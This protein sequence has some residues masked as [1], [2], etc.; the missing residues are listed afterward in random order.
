MWFG[1]LVTMDWF[2]DVWMKEVFANF[3]AAKIV[4]PSFPEVNHDLRFMLAHYPSAYAVDRSQGT[5]PIQQ[6]LEN[7]KNAGT[8]YGSII[9]QKAP[10][11]MRKLERRIGE[12]AMK[13]GLQQYLNAYS[14][15]NASWDDLITILDDQSEDDISSW[16]SKWVKEKGMA[17]ISAWMRTRKDSTVQKMN[18]FQRDM[19]ND[20]RTWPQQL[21]IM[22]IARDSTSQTNVDIEEYHVELADLEGTP[23]PDFIMPNAGGYG[24]GYFRLGPQTTHRLLTRM[25]EFDDPIVRGAG[26]MNLYERVLYGQTTPA[27]L[28]TSLQEQLVMEQEQLIVQRMLNYIETLYWKFLLPEDRISAADSVEQLLWQQL[29]QAEDS[30]VK[31]VYFNSFRSVILSEAG[32][33]R[34][35]KIWLKELKV[36][37]LSLSETD[38]T[39]MAYELALRLP[40][41]S[42]N[43][44]AEQLNRVSNADR[45]ARMKFISPALSPDQDTRDAFFE[46]LKD[47]ENRAHEPWVQQALGFLHHPLRA[48]KSLGY[49]APT[50]EMLE[51]IQLTGDIFFPKRVLDNT[52]SGHQSPLAVDAVR[53]FLYRNNH[54]P[55]NLKNKILQA[56]DLTFRAAEILEDDKSNGVIK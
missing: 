7:L 46:S 27:V 34:L 44:L 43:I 28:I 36:Q 14:F 50:L 12:E 26:W 16:S 15:G 24:Y 41:Q 25:H 31:L 2:S 6:P 40:E 32:V 29:E 11:V 33:D 54:Y 17:M 20:E 39:N 1:D 10:I 47:V 38:Y 22:L 23:E 42:A 3:M 56:S 18:I 30:R 53:Q 35:H 49:I 4:N 19:N 8:L 51:E 45:K 9:Y 21:T 48:E 37:G 5:H 52:F 55:E 13:T